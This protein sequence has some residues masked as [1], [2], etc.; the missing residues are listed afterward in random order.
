MQLQ[1]VVLIFAIFCDLL[2]F[3][4]LIPDVQLRAEQMGAAGWLI[5]AILASTFVTQFIVSPRWGALSDRIGRKPVLVACTVLSGAG[6]LVYGLATSLAIIVASRLLAGFGSANVAVA[7]AYI[8]DRSTEAERTKAMGQIG[9]AISAGLILGPAVGGKLASIGGNQLIGFVAGGASLLGALL[10]M[11]ILEGGRPEKAPSEPKGKAPLVDLR[12]LKDVPGL[13]QL[14]LVVVVAWF[15][16]ATLEGTFGRLIKANLGYGQYEFGVIFGYES[17][18][19]VIIQGAA[20]AWLATR[21]S[22][23]KLL[24]IG[25]LLQ[26]LGLALTPFAPGFAALIACSTLY[27]VG[28][29]VANPTV[30]SLC[31]KITPEERQGELFGLLQSARAV[32]FVLGPVLGGALFDVVHSGPY[33]L[34]GI[35][36]AAAAMLARAPGSQPRAG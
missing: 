32:G 29:S 3:G 1:K 25:F 27:A 8:A 5:G 11:L 14:V 28:S 31:S 21:V 9:A 17:L 24:R 35:V 30:N 26:G 33:L 18:L 10:L 15:S 7:Q 12:I 2:G 19:S 22:D 16:L 36:C 4:M 34:A 23:L 6:M 13:S 20:L